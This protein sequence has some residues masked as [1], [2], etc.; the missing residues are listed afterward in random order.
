MRFSFEHDN[1]FDL[2]TIRVTG[3]NRRPVDSIKLL[4]FAF[5]YYQKTGCTQFIIDMTQATIIG[6]TADAYNTGVSPKKIGFKAHGP[7][8]V[9]IVYSDDLAEHKFIENVLVNRGYNVCIFNDI[10][11]ARQWMLPK[12]VRVEP[13][14]QMLES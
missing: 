5:E 11:E 6:D 3:E 12:S 1:Q 2:C 7:F 8:K 9:A 13:E 10:D 14:E 4:K